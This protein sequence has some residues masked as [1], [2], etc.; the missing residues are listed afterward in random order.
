[1]EEFYCDAQ[2]IQGQ[3]EECEEALENYMETGELSEE[4]KEEYE[5]ELNN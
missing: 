4:F 5:Y 3:G 1:M 2:D